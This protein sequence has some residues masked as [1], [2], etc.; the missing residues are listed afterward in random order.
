MPSP[1]G[2]Y[3]HHVAG[4]ATLRGKH[5]YEWLRRLAPYL[6]GEH[7]LTQLTQALSAAQRQMVTDLVGML[8]AQGFVTDA[9]EDRPHMLTEA[10]RQTYAAEIAF[11]RY[12]LDSA[13]YRFQRY[14]QAKV[15]MVGT[16]PLLVPL[17]QACLGTGSR[18]VQVTAAIPEQ[19][20][21]LR[22]A[23][24]AARRDAEQRVEV[25]GQGGTEEILADGLAGADVVLQIVTVG[26]EED[27]LAM[28]EATDQAGAV[29]GQVLV[30]DD[31]AWL[32]PVGHPARTGAGSAWRRLGAL[33]PADPEDIHQAGSAGQD[34]A[35]WL[36]GPMP[37]LVAGRL[38][39]A[40][41]RALTGLDEQSGSSSEPAAVLTVL[42]LRALNSQVHDFLPHPLARPLSDAASYTEPPTGADADTPAAQAAQAAIAALAAGSALEAGQLLDAASAAVDSRIGLFGTLDE[43][44]FTQ[45]PLAVY[46]ATVS[47]PCGLLPAWA[48][49]VTVIGYGA[50]SDQARVRTLCAAFATYGSLAIDTRRLRPPADQSGTTG[51]VP[52][53]GDLAG[54]R[55]WGT[56]LIDGA[57]RP[58]PAARAF[59]ALAGPAVP[60]RAPVGA[61]AELSWAAAVSAGLR[62]HCQAL[63][64]ARLDHA[65]EPFP[66]VPLTAWVLDEPLVLDEQGAELLSL[67]DTARQP[68]ACYD[69]TALLDLPTY[70]FCLGAT[71]VA[72][73]CAGT[74][75]EAMTEGLEQALL[76]WQADTQGRTA[77]APAAPPA[78]PERLRG[79]LAPNWKPT[80][81]GVAARPAE[82]LLAQTGCRPVAVPLDHDPEAVRILPYLV[83]VVLL[84]DCHPPD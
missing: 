38:C 75:A 4:E 22:D 26:Q 73:C 63:L 52:G 36:T 61:A 9:R 15:L 71:T 3:L 67:L 74:S 33:H 11:I 55:V 12:A 40:L 53:A 76:A 68:V 28:T 47:D 19:A 39:L 37:A 7:E 78:L 42:D 41:F 58:V 77:Y 6:T 32:G 31:E 45:V 64:A 49:P 24:E 23:G 44:N 14:R 1:E 59:P 69:L 72:L 62:Q 8:H 25:V 84:N 66:Q 30:R 81:D 43:E 48:P 79:P 27:L 51:D 16:G 70:A 2:V 10:E 80:L 35:G 17:V 56:D 60:Y 83:Q 29:L 50:D 20:Q 57:L 21:Q 82:L 46:R 18:T 54:V 5:S 13:E 34:P 65:T